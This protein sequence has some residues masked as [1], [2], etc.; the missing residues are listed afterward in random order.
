MNSVTDSPNSLPVSVEPGEKFVLGAWFALCLLGI[1]ALMANAP[2]PRRVLLFA[3]LIFFVVACF[4]HRDLWRQTSGFLPW[5]GLVL[6]SALWS[7]LPAMTMVDALWEVFCPIAACLLAMFLAE[8]VGGRQVLWPFTA[9]ALFAFPCLLGALHE[10]ASLWPAG[11]R[12]FFSGYAGRGV[13]STQGIFLLVIG[14]ALLWGQSR[15]S[16]RNLRQVGLGLWLLL[17]GLLLGVL[18]HN[19][20]FWFALLCAFLPWSGLFFQLPGHQKKKLGACVFALVFAGTLYSLSHP[21]TP[22]QGTAARSVVAV[23]A[24]LDEDPRWYI[25]KRWLE[26]AE[27]K[28]FLGWGYGSRL[29]PRIG[30]KEVPAGFGDQDWAAQHHGHNVLI[31]IFVQT[32]IFGVLAFLLMLRHLYRLVLCSRRGTELTERS[33]W[34]LA[35]LSLVFAALAKSMTDDF[36]WGPAG[37]LMWLFV[38][39]TTGL[40]RRA[41]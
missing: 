1:S 20:M 27:R 21:K 35:A 22:E 6:T 9:V 37:I 41:N 8:K 10:H 39:I 32:G 30:E 23:G 15:R 12:G 16:V 19:R 33:F 13:A 4:R 25:W 18:G 7:P 28:P 36:F 17:S 11:A 40:A 5:C 26:V 24:S 31:N 14:G 38:G 3:V 2:G 29:L 34:R